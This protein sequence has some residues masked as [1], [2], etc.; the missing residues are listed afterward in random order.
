MPRRRFSQQVGSQRILTRIRAVTESP[1]KEIGE[2][3]FGVFS[4]LQDADNR[5]DLNNFA[6][7]S[8]TFDR[9]VDL[10]PATYGERFYFDAAMIQASVDSLSNQQ[11]TFNP[12]I[13]PRHSNKW[14]HQSLPMPSGSKTEIDMVDFILFPGQD[15]IN[16][17]NLLSYPFLLH[18]LGHNILFKY[19]DAFRSGFKQ[20]LEAITNKL[21]LAS[22]ADQG[23]VRLQSQQSVETVRRHWEPTADHKNWAYELA[24]DILALW[25]MGPAYLAAFIDETD[26]PGIDPFLLQ[27]HPPYELRAKVLV[28][29]AKSIGW[30]KHCDALNQLLVDWR[31][32]QQTRHSSEVNRYVALSNEQIL[33]SCIGFALETCKALQLPQCTEE[34]VSKLKRSLGH[35]D[36]PELGLDLIIAAWLV[37]EERGDDAYQV[38]QS[39]TIQGLQQ[40]ITQ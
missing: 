11:L 5:R 19:D 16:E 21:A 15:D 20:T 1:L 4:E 22:I 29:V 23:A 26:K 38:W 9:I 30:Q 14:G 25:I 31:T 6:D 8:H 2:K 28:Q 17:V 18:E 7:L 24:I 10:F 37:H 13:V 12:M 32:S 33:E 3:L 34:V 27:A 39:R 35:N 40:Y 36:I